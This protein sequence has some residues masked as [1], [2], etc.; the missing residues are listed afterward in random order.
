MAQKIFQ[1]SMN[2]SFGD[3]PGV[4]T[5]I[6]DILVWGSSNEEQQYY[7]DVKRLVEL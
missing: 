3:L 7:R 1:K 2:Q 6:D 4:E 5:D